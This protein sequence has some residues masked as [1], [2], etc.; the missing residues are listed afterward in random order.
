M[1]EWPNGSAAG[2]LS[3]GPSVAAFQKLL[4]GR[5]FCA[6]PTPRFYRHRLE[7]LRLRLRTLSG[8][9]P[10]SAGGGICVTRPIPFR[11]A[12]DITFM[13]AHLRSVGLP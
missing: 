3:K 8:T 12:E 9:K 4:L 7:E 2:G 13:S 6:Q 10:M 11:R 5:R 1:M